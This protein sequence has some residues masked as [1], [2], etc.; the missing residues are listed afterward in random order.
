MGEGTQAL[1][2]E[3]DVFPVVMKRHEPTPEVGNAP[4]FTESDTIVI[5]KVKGVN[6]PPSLS[7]ASSSPHEAGGVTGVVSQSLTTAAASLLDLM[8]TGTME[9]W[10]ASPRGVP[11]SWSMRYV[12]SVWLRGSGDN[13][14][15]SQKPLTLR[16]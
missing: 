8:T 10:L 5:E 1:N 4:T 14:S 9:T 11:L 16:L 2:V 3:N 6:E 15:S 13:S 12:P 7:A